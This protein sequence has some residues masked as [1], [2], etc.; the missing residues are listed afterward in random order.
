MVRGNSCTRK[1]S[2]QMVARSSKGA[3]S[4][5]LVIL[6]M[7]KFS[8]FESANPTGSYGRLKLPVNPAKALKAQVPLRTA[9]RRENRFIRV[10]RHAEHDGSVRFAQGGPHRKLPEVGI[11]LHQVVRSGPDK[12]HSTCLSEA[13]RL[14][15][16]VHCLPELNRKLTRS[17]PKSVN[18]LGKMRLFDVVGRE[19]I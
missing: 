9:K 15:I 11:T 4:K 3:H 10:F 13:N 2:A 14:A 17:H 8:D 16:T 5:A 6:S 1:S 18:I 12:D 7:T 19:Y